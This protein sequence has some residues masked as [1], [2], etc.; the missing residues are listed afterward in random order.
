MPKPYPEEF[1]PDVAAVTSKHEDPLSQIARD[2]GI[3][4]TTRD[5]RTN[6]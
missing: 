5:C 6:R 4:E 2:F 3:S 1:R